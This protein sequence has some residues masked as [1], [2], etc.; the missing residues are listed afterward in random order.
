MPLK[1][2]DKYSE[3][4]VETGTLNGAGI[5]TALRSGYSKV[6]SIELDDNFYSIAKQTF[7]NFNNVE[8]VHGDSG[9]VLGDS[10]KNV[11]ENITFWLDGHYSGEGT[12]YGIE[13]FPLKQELMHIKNH[14]IKTH[15]ILID[16]VRCWKEYSPELNFDKIIELVQSINKDYSFYFTEGFIEDDV[17]V[18]KVD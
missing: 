4:F 5:I 11:N 2:L 13:E 12:A 15:T 14:P 18:C 9:I 16:D 3:V 6:I 10:I 17:L 1:H 8:I 7:S